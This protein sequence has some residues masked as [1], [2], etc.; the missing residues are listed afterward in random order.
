MGIATVVYGLIEAPTHGWTSINT[1]GVLLLGVAVV[2]LFVAWELRTSSPIYRFHGIGPG[3]RVR[4]RTGTHRIARNVT[5]GVRVYRV[6]WL[7]CARA[8]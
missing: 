7:A 3:S 6:R 5:V 2:G 4:W 1:L 8:S